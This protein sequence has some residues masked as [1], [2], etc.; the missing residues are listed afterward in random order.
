MPIGRVADAKRKYIAFICIWAQAVVKAD[1]PVVRICAS[2]RHGKTLLDELDRDMKRT[3]Q[4]RDELR[5]KLRD[6][7]RKHIE[8]KR[9]AKLAKLQAE[10][11]ARQR[12]EER[13]ALEQEQPPTTPAM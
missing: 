11:V 7:D 8:L 10:A 9:V 3:R 6:E 1:I 2:R 5:A 12:Q 4:D 13:E